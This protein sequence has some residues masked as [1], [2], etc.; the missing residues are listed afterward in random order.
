MEKYYRS[1]ALQIRA[2]QWSVTAS[3]QPLTAHIYHVMI[4]VS[5]DFSKKSFL[6]ISGLGM[7]PALS[8]AQMKKK[9]AWAGDEKP[10]QRQSCV[11]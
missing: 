5:G 9:E 11:G 1:T 4:I 7:T 6:C 8:P 2:G 3:L 10:A